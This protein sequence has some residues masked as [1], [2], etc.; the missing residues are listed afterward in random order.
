LKAKEDMPTKILVVEDEAITG[1]HLHDILV[2]L[3]YDVV[4]VVSSGEDAIAAAEQ[5]RPDLALMDIRLKGALEGTETADILRSRYNVPSIF[6]T[7]HADR[8][9]L[10]KAKSARPLGYIVK[11]FQE[12]ELQAC[13]EMALHRQREEQH[14]E[15]QR[16]STEAALNG[17]GQAVVSV[18]KDQS[19]RV[20]NRAAES[21]TGW[22]QSDAIGSRLSDVVDINWSEG[23]GKNPVDRTLDGKGP[24]DI[25]LGAFLVCGGERRHV[26]G[27]VTPL[28][29]HRGA[30]SG[31]VLVFGPPVSRGGSSLGPEEQYT[32]DLDFGRVR[33]VAASQAMKRVVHFARRVAASEATTVLLEGESGTGKDVF[34]QFMHYSGIRQSGPYVPL[35]CAAIPETLLESELFGHEKGAFTDAKTVKRGLFEMAH[36]GTIFLDEIGE[37]PV[38]LQTKL[39]RVLENQTFRRLGGTADIQVNVRFTAATNRKLTEA[40]QQGKFR[41]DLYYR[42]NLIQVVL[43]P[44]RERRDDI[45]PLARYFVRIYNDKYK[46]SLY[47]LSNEAEEMLLEYAW[48][49]NIRELRNV[50]ERGVLLEESPWIEKASLQMEGDAP[51]AEPEVARAAAAGQQPAPAATQ[52]PPGVTLNEAERTLLLKALEAAQWN[53]TRAAVAL[54]ISRDTLRYRIKKYGMVGPH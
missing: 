9:T 43:P 6:L 24:Q 14:A 38:V 42:L 8:A 45:V 18:D 34:A 31:A 50:I 39:L 37:M 22:K 2:D 11:P 17:L 20:F 47:G 7:A 32:E 53:Q 40:I 51:R 21:W 13:I 19:I 44:L 46:R 33:I 28:L 4:G 16:I 36:G 52:L 27:Q 26:S 54:G 35:N 10:D 15:A 1:E 5:D 3:G 41:M 48:P 23:T 29:D 49:G 12:P 25:T 30:L